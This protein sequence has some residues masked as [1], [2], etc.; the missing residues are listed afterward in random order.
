MAPIHVM[1]EWADKYKGKF[2]DGWDAYRERVFK[3]AKEKGWIPADAQT[4]PPARDDAVLGQHP[5][6]QRSPFSAA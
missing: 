6:G 2:D 5:R 4:H 1:K 3:R